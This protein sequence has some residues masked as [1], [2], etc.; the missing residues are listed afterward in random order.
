MNPN[1]AAVGR[2]PEIRLIQYLRGIAAVMVVFYHASGM[3]PST[4]DWP[5]IGQRGVDVFF[6]ISGFV[7]TYSTAAG[8]MTPADF[9]FKRVMRVV[10]LY[11]IVLAYSSRSQWMSGIA[12]LDIA[13]DFAFV[14]RFSSGNAGPI[15]PAMVP[16]WT[17]NY[18][19]YFYLLF[20]LCMFLGRWRLPAIVTLL[21]A[22]MLGNLWPQPGNAPYTFYTHPIA[23]EFA[24]G[25][26]IAYVYLHWPRPR[27]VPLLSGL[28][29]GAAVALLA[30]GNV[31]H[32]AR[33]L[34]AGVPATF[35]VYAAA[36]LSP[37]IKSGSTALGVL[38]DASYSIYLF[39]QTGF[40]VATRVLGALGRPLPLWA[41]VAIF[42]AFGISLG[43]LMHYALEKPLL[44]LTRRG[45]DQA[46]RHM[47][48][49]P[50]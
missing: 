29:I 50:R 21:A 36:C 26:A 44:K 28:L 7:M 2:L 33:W 35:I 9:F 43:I 14:P 38:G 11:W 24:F 41:T 8:D 45:W 1:V 12:T 3:A 13:K 4:P 46:R 34:H 5:A 15:W 48:L 32:A 16:G 22:S 37:L 42:L 18:E 39:H 20:A 31:E 40:G 10:P 6:V 23:L 27:S 30:G 17:I 19:M 49:A 25:I 47:R